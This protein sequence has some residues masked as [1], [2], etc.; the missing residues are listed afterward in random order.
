MWRTSLKVA[1]LNFLVHAVVLQARDQSGFISIDCGGSNSTD[2]ELDI[3]YISDDDFISSGEPESVNSDL[4]SYF[5]QEQLQNLRSFP[6]GKRNCYKINNITIGFLYLIRLQF[7][8]GNYDG[9][10]KFPEFDVFLGVNKWDTVSVG[11]D[12]NVNVNTVIRMKEIIHRASREYISICLVKKRGTPF[13]STID[14]RPLK[15]DTY[16]TPSGGSLVTCSRQDLGHLSSTSSSSISYHRFKDDPYDRIWTRSSKQYAEWA[17]LSDSNT[18]TADSFSQNDYQVPADVMRTAITPANASDPLVVQSNIPTAQSDEYHIYMHF[19]DL[20][21][22]AGLINNPI[23]E[24]NIL[25]DNMPLSEYL[26][27]PSLSAKTI[28]T[29]VNN[30]INITISFQMTSRSTLP[31]IIN[32][33]EAYRFIPFNQLDTFQADVDAITRI[34]SV[35]GLTTRDD[36]WQ[37]DPCGP[38][39]YMSEWDG[40]N[41][42]RQ[43][44]ESPRISALN[45]SSSGL[46][47]TIDLSLS[48]LTM[49]EMLDLSNNDLNGQIPNFLSQLHNL[50]ILNLAGNNLSGSVPSILLEKSNE[51]SLLLNVDQNPYLLCESGGC[52]EKKKKPL[53]VAAAIGILVTLLVIVAAAAIVWTLKKRKTKKEKTPREIKQDDDVSL[54]FKNKIYSYSDI[55]KITNNFRKILGK[56]GFGTVYMGHV[57]DAPVAVKMLSQ[58]SVQG[59]QQFQAEVKILM[60]VHHRNL[61]SLVGYCNEGSNKALI[62]EYMANGNL[63]E[64]LLGTKFLSWKD[65]LC[66][67]VDA[68][69]GLEYLHNGCKPPIIHRDVKASNILLTENLHAKLSDFGLSKSIPTDGRSHVSTVVAGTAGYLDPNYYQSSRLTEKSDVYS[70][71]VVLLE[72]ITSQAAIRMAEDDD[73]DNDGKTHHLSH[74]VS[75]KVER[76]DIHGIV[77]SRLGEDFDC[78]SAWKIVETALTCVS[79]NSNERPIMS[80]VLIELKN[81]LAMELSRTNYG[82]G[83]N[84]NNGDSSVELVF[85]NANE[86][87]PLAR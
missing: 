61:T 75:S 31:P 70:F 60:R 18:V 63:R 6:K 80:E 12:D 56:G 85:V 72:L 41:C 59:Y 19:L 34:Q 42:T 43:L 10:S 84:N 32:A 58:S 21:F 3:Q 30:E 29:T 86:S 49:L 25:V 68:A 8:Y 14:L 65:R 24:F 20:E 69:Q 81:A 50:K 36:Q 57:D 7:A 40:L 51:G 67:A 76:G 23:R 48:Q 66:I 44:D 28:N 64:H 47:G 1:L 77:D 71:G 54:N 45:L 79:Q 37:G 2:D 9:L 73:D 55:L 74:W 11:A 13:I 4:R 17:M 62:Y 26:V 5:V 53:L 27:L 33:I 83:V 16:F 52:K 39:G 87:T 82:G 38:A 22:A 46:T 78:S 35:Y 15:N